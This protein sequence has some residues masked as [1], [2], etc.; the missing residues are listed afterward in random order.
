MNS[1]MK[2]IKNILVM[3]AVLATVTACDRDFE[4]DNIA[5]GTIRFPA[6]QLTGDEVV[7]VNQGGTYSDAGATASLGPED[8]TSKLEMSTDLDLTSPGVYTVDYSVTNVNELEQETTVTEQ[9]IIVV[10]P[11]NP[12]TAVDLSG[13][14]HRA[15]AT[16]VGVVTWTKVAPGLYIN[17]NVGGVIAPSPAVIPV[18]VF[19]YADGTISI[20]EQPVPNGYGVL[21]ANITL[22]ATGYTLAIPDTPGFGTQNRIFVKQ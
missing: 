1:T 13:T 10:A 8:I 9:R 19:H 15:Q 2:K 3:I 4:S 20:P 12:N 17:D 6:I 21:D 7:I 18:F 22:T 11:S 14:Y 16:G 5:V